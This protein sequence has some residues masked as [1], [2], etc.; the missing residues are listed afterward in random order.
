MAEQGEDTLHQVDLGGFD[1]RRPI[2]KRKN[3]KRKNPQD[4]QAK[5]PPTKDAA[6]NMIQKPK[7]EIYYEMGAMRVPAEI[8]GGYHAETHAL[9]ER[10]TGS[11]SVDNLISFTRSPRAKG[12]LP[13]KK[14]H[15][16]RG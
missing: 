2:R 12:S 13:S 8:L 4:P 16:S 10:S 5:E 7:Q 15:I 6:R 1:T 3:H 9:R 14:F 11:L